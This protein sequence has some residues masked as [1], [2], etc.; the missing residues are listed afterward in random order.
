MSIAVSADTAKL[1]D[2]GLSATTFFFAILWA[3]SAHDMYVQIFALSDPS[4]SQASVLKEITRKIS[5]QSQYC[6]VRPFGREDFIV[7]GPSS[8]FYPQKPQM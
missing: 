1:A 2:L 5:I 4:S 6:F 3:D 7:V 8:L